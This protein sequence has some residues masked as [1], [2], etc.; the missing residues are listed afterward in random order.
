MQKLLEFF[1]KI[2]KAT[3]NIYFIPCIVAVNI[4]QKYKKT[5]LTVT[6]YY[7]KTQS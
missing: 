3:N 6:R 7:V 4:T 5:Y 1:R 2:R